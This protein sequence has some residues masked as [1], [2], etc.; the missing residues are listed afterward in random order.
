[1]LLAKYLCDRAYFWGPFLCD[2]VQGVERFAINPR[3]FPSQVPHGV[4]LF[5]LYCLPSYQCTSYTQQDKYE[6]CKILQQLSKRKCFQHFF[7][8]STISLSENSSVQYL[9]SNRRLPLTEG[10]I[11]VVARKTEKRNG[12]ETNSKF[13][14]HMIH[15]ISTVEN[16]LYIAVHVILHTHTLYK[17]ILR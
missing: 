3:H 1:M 9:N 2:R 8:P 11:F 17:R 12:F 14:H 15:A 7:A 6:N 4:L 5:F 16:V 10:I 13:G